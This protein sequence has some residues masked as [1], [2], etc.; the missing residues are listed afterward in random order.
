MPL[1]ST[2]CTFKQLSA[3]ELRLCGSAAKVRSGP[4][5]APRRG[6]ESRKKQNGGGRKS[7]HSNLVGVTT[8][9]AHMC[10]EIP[11]L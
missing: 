8:L 11:D 1:G 4:A 3:G 9:V 6:A 7:G 2:F 5:R 10:S